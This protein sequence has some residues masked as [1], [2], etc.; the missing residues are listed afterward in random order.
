MQLYLVR[1]GAAKPQEE[2]PSRPL[3]ARGAAEVERMAV[4]AAH[5]GVCVGQ[6][7]HSSKLR[8]RQT[9]QIFAGALAPAQGVVDA[10]GLE[11]EDDVLPFAKALQRE[12]GPLMIVGH[13]PFL[14]RLAACLLAG[15]P[16]SLLVRFD[17]VSIVSL[18]HKN[19]RWSLEW[20]LSPEVV[21]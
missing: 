12:A 3:T 20:A 4:F 5:L 15:H 11:P 7:R 17:H 9:A 21:R 13:L 16:E 8:A 10:S 6:I 19:G 1:H 18:V 14:V 2:D